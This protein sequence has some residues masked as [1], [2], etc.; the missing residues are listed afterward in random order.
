MT[1]LLVMSVCLVSCQQ[2][3]LIGELPAAREGYVA[4]RFSADIPV[5]ETQN[6]STRSVD[7]DGGRRADHDPV[8]LRQLRFFY[9]DRKSRPFPDG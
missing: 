5:M 4:L 1:A 7:P 9:H 8:L 3:E 2:N 6:V